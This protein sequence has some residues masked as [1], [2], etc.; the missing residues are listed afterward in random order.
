M[1]ILKIAYKQVIFNL[2]IPDHQR[3]EKKKEEKF[4]FIAENTMM[5]TW[6]TNL[7]L[8]THYQG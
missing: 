4:Q 7:H 3:Q 1:N 2:C 5:P 8:K 6:D